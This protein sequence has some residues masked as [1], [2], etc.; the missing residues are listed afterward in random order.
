MT[1]GVRFDIGPEMTAVC[2][3][4]WTGKDSGV[5]FDIGPE[6]TVV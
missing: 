3:R 2:D 5:R 6:M 1:A 4:F